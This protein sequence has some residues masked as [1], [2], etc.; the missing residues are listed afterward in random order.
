MEITLR[1]KL[2]QCLARRVHNGHFKSPS[3]VVNFALNKLQKD[4]E[5]L[6]WLQHEIQKGTDSLDRGAG[7]RW[8]VEE[9]KAT[10]LRRVARH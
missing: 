6:Q 5:D 3:D 2:K 7:I 10:L 8:D 1:P 9:Q 4:E